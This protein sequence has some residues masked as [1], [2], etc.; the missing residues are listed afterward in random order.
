[1]RE[2]TCVLLVALCGRPT[3]ELDTLPGMLARLPLA[4]ERVLRD[5]VAWDH[6]PRCEETPVTPVLGLETA[7]PVA[8]C[9]LR[10]RLVDCAT[11][12]VVGSTAYSPP[13]SVIRD[14]S[15]L[16]ASPV[17]DCATWA[18][19]NVSPAGEFGLVL[20][21]SRDAI[22]AGLSSFSFR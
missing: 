9:T 15:V 19:G 13:S 4:P 11:E 20:G 3:E 5:R 22:L 7:S 2:G 12:D 14:D 1:V 10:L 18:L 16:A 21:V 17:S 6:P 8:V